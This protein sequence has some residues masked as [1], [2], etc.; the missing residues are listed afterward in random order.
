M[1][2]PERPYVA[3][4]GGSEGRRNWWI[5]AAWAVGVLVIF[6]VFVRIAMSLPV[7]SDA[8]NNALQA[9]DMLHGNFL[10]HNWVIGDAT[11][12][13]FDLPVTA[14]AEAFLGVN[15]LAVHV[16]LA[17]TFLIVAVLALAIARIDCR[18]AA[19][20][21]RCAVVVAVMTAG[22][23]DSFIFLLKPDHAATSA[24]LLA[25]FLLIDRA[26]SRWFTPL[27][28]FVIL[29]A[30]QIGD[31]LVLYVAVPTIILVSLY[32]WVSGGGPRSSGLRTAA[33]AALSVPAA[34]LARAMMVR[35]GGYAMVAPDSSWAPI[36]SL[37]RH[38]T[39]TAQNIGTLF[40]VIP[41]PS[42]ALGV[43][44]SAF[45]TLCLL[46]ATFGFGKTACNWRKASWAEQLLCM[47][48]VV[49]IAAYAFSRLAGTSSPYDLAPIVPCSAVL[50]ARAVVPAAIGSAWRAR[51]AIA[52]AAAAALLP[53]TTAARRPP[54]TMPASVR[55]VDWLDA[56]GL[57]YGIAGY[58]NASALTVVSGN[59]VQIRAVQPWHGKLAVLEWETDNAWYVAS[60]HD[61]TFALAGR[62][63]AS[64]ANVM[65]QPVFERY[66]GKPAATYSIYGWRVL[67]YHR[68]LLRSLVPGC[69]S[70]A[71]RHDLPSAIASRGNEADT[72]NVLCPRQLERQ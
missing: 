28:L 21:V 58:W 56:H 65:T 57:R 49:N 20:A 38:L 9:W 4:R 14:I 19:T 55:L 12:Y 3:S 32:R 47:A 27:V 50:A 48:I 41:H 2:D 25:C 61:A 35:L 70:P 54:Q 42:S 15:P 34:V 59:Q 18:G 26:P 46:A 7:D 63:R 24:F 30:G 68:N 53:L 43:V 5:A 40:G 44:G 31:A 51:V 37:G 16:A 66:L 39:L 22:L 17:L 13:T 33:A 10:L 29:C 45:G 71:D 8:A 52:A 23:A 67:V 1:L 6:A 36:S 72:D 62:A 64:V 60:R 11:Y 69:P